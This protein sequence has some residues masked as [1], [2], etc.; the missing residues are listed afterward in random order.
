MDLHMHMSEAARLSLSALHCFAFLLHPKLLF[1]RDLWLWEAKG[2]WGR[3]GYRADRLTS[4][5]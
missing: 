2:R 5:A 1:L 4:R 3:K